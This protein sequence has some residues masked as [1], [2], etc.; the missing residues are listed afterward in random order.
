MNKTMYTV[1]WVKRGSQFQSCNIESISILRE[2][3]VPGNEQKQYLAIDKNG[4]E[5]RI[6][7]RFCYATE[8]EA[9]IGA[10]AEISEQVKKDKVEL[11]DATIELNGMRSNLRS[12]ELQI[13][14]RDKNL[15]KQFQNLVAMLEF[16]GQ[17]DTKIDERI[18]QLKSNVAD[19]I[20]AGNLLLNDR[21]F[22][23]QSRNNTSDHEALKAAF[24]LIGE[25]NVVGY[26]QVR[27]IIESRHQQIAYFNPVEIAA[28]DSE[29]RDSGPRM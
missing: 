5:F 7:P 20:G 13:A 2:I 17:I 29:E 23:D 27:Q 16:Q 8:V 22:N 3:T 9:L 15:T 18:H 19:L 6:F 28:D 10:K 26:S 4:E 21:G 1:V 25:G 12:L 11:A 14:E 24:K